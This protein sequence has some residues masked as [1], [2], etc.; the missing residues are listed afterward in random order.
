M[1]NL[2]RNTQEYIKNINRYLM[3]EDNQK[4]RTQ[5]CRPRRHLQGGGRFAAAPLG[6]PSKAAP[7]C[8]VFLIILYHRYS[9]IYLY[10]SCR[11]LHIFLEYSL[12]I[13]IYIFPVYFPCMFPWVFLNLFRQQYHFSNKICGGDRKL[14]SR[15]SIWGTHTSKKTRIYFLEGNA[16]L[17]RKAI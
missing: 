17:C 7:L 1:R 6:A 14:S 5:R 15:F 12:Y 10:Y 8:S 9:W 16:F 2:Y 3:I 11:F 13:Y 4:H